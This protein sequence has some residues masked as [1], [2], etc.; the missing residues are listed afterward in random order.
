MGA[1]YYA[2][3]IKE[4][5]GSTWITWRNAVYWRGEQYNRLLTVNRPLIVHQNLPHN[6]VCFPAQPALG[7]FNVPLRSNHA[8]W[9]ACSCV[10]AGW[11]LYCWWRV[12]L[13]NIDIPMF[14]SLVQ[15]RYSI[16]YSIVLNYCG[17]PIYQFRHLM[18]F[19]FLNTGMPW[20]NRSIFL[21]LKVSLV[22]YFF[23]S[24]KAT[25]FHSWRSFLGCYYYID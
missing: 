24:S 17:M 25:W 5:A 16:C 7:W 13:L 23:S 19:F 2:L 18:G 9:I 3:R 22:V 20:Y 11:L 6:P 12:C 21:Q 10:A 14:L 8:A 1:H 15:T 4:E